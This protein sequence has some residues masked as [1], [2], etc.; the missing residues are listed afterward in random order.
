MK[1][2]LGFM[3][4]LVLLLVSPGLATEE[5]PE[6]GI[7]VKNI[8]GRHSNLL[9]KNLSAYDAVLVITPVNKPGKTLLAVYVRGNE[10]LKVPNITSGSYSCWFTHG[11]AWDPETNRFAE[12]AYYARLT[13]TMRFLRTQRRY[14]KYTVQLG[15]IENLG[16]P[17]P[18]K[19]IDLEQYGMAWV[20]EP[21]FPTWEDKD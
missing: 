2:I 17:E 8:S 21:D 16:P 12:N 1:R 3:V 14:T 10:E 5:Q 9:I 15:P 7:L 13:K 18:A 20:E 4:L 11:S 19:A 6:S